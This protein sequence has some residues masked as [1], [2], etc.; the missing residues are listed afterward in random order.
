MPVTIAQ[1]VHYS[2]HGGGGKFVLLILCG[3][4][5]LLCA[6]IIRSWYVRS[7]DLDRKYAKRRRRLAQLN[8]EIAYLEEH[9]LTKAGTFD[10]PLKDLRVER[11]AV[12]EELKLIE[13]ARRR[14]GMTK[15]CPDAACRHE[16]AADA[17]HC[18][19]CGRALV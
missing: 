10:T 13:E 15:M 11:A 4:L 6:L 14:A 16:N 17:R 2:V 5:I 8:E 12:E 3:A 18:A 19:R 1:H 7:S 9:G